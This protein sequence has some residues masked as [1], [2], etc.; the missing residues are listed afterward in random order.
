MIS[1]LMWRMTFRCNKR[2]KYCFNE[3]FDDKV[4]H[5]CEE[6]MDL[7]YLKKFVERFGVKKVYLSGGEPAVEEGLEGIIKEISTFSKVVLFTNGLLFEKYNVGEI[8]AMPLSAINTTVDLYDIINY[9]AYFNNLMKNFKLIKLQN[10][11]MKVNVQIMIDNQYY[12]VVDSVGYDCMKSN[13]DR[14]LWQPLTVPANSPLYATT[15]EGMRPEKAERIIC[16]LKKRNQGEMADHIT[17]LAEVIGDTGAK[18][19][20]MGKEYITMNPDMSISICPHINN[21]YINEQ[22]LLQIN[23]SLQPFFCEKFSMRCFSLYSHLKR[24]FM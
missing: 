15:L 24:R 2:C 13:T 3:V 14:I 10:P 18:K 22:E 8:S 5:L 21:H 16:D 11:N 23:E 9:S 12:E 6:K 20:L 1:E 4:N 17:N 7:E 19:C